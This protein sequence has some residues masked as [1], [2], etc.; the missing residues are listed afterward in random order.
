VSASAEEA[1]PR[2]VCEGLS[3][4]FGGVQAVEDV[5]FSVRG[6]EIF[7]LLGPNG[8]GKT[9]TLRM[10]VTLLRPDRGW[11]RVCGYDTTQ[12]AEEVRRRV[13]YQTGDTQLYE[14]LT[15]VEFLEYFGRLQGMPIQAVRR[16]V[17][18]L[19]GELGF[20]SYRGRL[21]G[22]LSTGQKQRVSIARALL[23][24][25][26]VLILDE[27]T[28]GLDIVS[29][30]FVVELLSRLRAEGRA[31]LYST[32]IMSEVELLCDRVAVIHGGRLRAMA[33]LAELIAQT[34]ESGLT[35]AFL[36]LIAAEDAAEE[37]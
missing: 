31:I 17:E 16:R 5:S 13:G 21:C 27:P 35:R 4:R 14:R 30:Q 37:R 6:G 34:G 10:L 8:A 26:P 19:T 12:A 11:A 24:D 33:P 15:P 3:L 36:S 23:H 32:H 22:T 20:G 28:S 7:G 9:T 1:E 18:E 2:V 29:A 25:P